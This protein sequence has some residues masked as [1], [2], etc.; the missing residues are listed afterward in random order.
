MSI[1]WGQGAAQSADDP[2]IKS[3]EK[4]WRLIDPNWYQGGQL[5]EI[6]YKQSDL[7]A[8][9]ECIVLEQLVDSSLNG[10]FVKW[11]ISELTADEIRTCGTATGDPTSDCVIRIEDNDPPWPKNRSVIIG[12]APGGQTLKKRHLYAITRIANSKTLKRLPKP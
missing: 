12:K 3:I 7:S 11:G 5:L 4:I 8:L 10:Q 6:A 2:S 9:R 1:I